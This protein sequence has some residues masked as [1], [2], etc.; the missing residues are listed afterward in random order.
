MKNLSPQMAGEIHAKLAKANGDPLAAFAGKGYFCRRPAGRVDGVM[1]R[2]LLPKV[3]NG[4]YLI[5]TE[6]EELPI[7]GW[8]GDWLGDRGAPKCYRPDY[9]DGMD[10]STSVQATY[11]IRLWQG[12]LL[13]FTFYR[14]G[15][16][17]EGKSGTQ[18]LVPE[19]LRSARHSN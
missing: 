2:V 12:K 5:D 18:W 13:G 3:Q 14:Y 1:V 6:G 11:A 9:P 17:T 19:Q 4:C 7:Y 10:L 15:D 16:G 8:E